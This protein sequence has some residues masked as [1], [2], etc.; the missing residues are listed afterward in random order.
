MYTVPSQ[1][2]STAR[3]WY[4]GHFNAYEDACEVMMRNVTSNKSNF[5]TLEAEVA[6]Q[7]GGR[8]GYCNY[9]TSPPQSPTHPSYRHNA[10]GVMF[11]SI[12]DAVG[13]RSHSHS[14]SLSHGS[15]ARNN[16]PFVRNYSG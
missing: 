13:P 2:E 3:Y 7:L 8:S 16:A 14:H 15:Q 1:F 12:G 6:P 4:S 11:G 10:P 5:T 9:T